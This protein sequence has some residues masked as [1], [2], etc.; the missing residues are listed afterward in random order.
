MGHGGNDSERGA[1]LAPPFVTQM[2]QKLWFK[3]RPMKWMWV[4]YSPV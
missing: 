3:A 2:A 1:I 4:L